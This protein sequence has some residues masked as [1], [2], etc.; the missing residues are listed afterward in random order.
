[1]FLEALLRVPDWQNLP[2]TV[3]AQTVQRSGFPSAYADDEVTARK[4]VSELHPTTGSY[5]TTTS[6]APSNGTT[7]VSVSTSSCQAGGV[8]TGATGKG[9][10]YPFK[11]AA[12]DIPDGWG[13]LTRECVSFVAWRMNVQMGWKPGQDYPFT[14]PKLG[15]GLWG[16]AVGWKDTVGSIY[17]MDHTPKVGAVAWW[18]AW[19]ASPSTT[20]VDSGHVAVVSGVHP[21]NGTIDIEEYNFGTNHMYNARTIPAA[22]VSAFI[23][24]ADVG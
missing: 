9:D 6:S 18:D 20:T 5:G 8:G 12:I 17:P 2:L 3:A 19:Y 23:H 11:D 13:T 15:V 1:M 21:E 24:V 22:D 10:D 14:V 4:V 7:P 16:N